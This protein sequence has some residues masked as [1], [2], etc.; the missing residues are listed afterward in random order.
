MLSS[1]VLPC[2]CI[3]R[4]WPCSQLQLSV[5]LVSLVQDSRHQLFL[6]YTAPEADLAPA[7]SP[8]IFSPPLLA[9]LHCR[10][11]AFKTAGKLPYDHPTESRE[12]K[13][14]MYNAEP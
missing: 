7:D 6:G 8:S 13:R 11:A 14:P 9:H 3:V 10:P 5:T 12:P 1:K 2:L 4:G